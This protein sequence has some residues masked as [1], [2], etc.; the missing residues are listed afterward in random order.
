MA[1]KICGVGVNDAD[2]KV[3]FYKTDG[4]R[5][6]CPFY[7]KWSS[8]INRCYNGS[9]STYDNSEVCEEWK[10]FSNFRKWMI[11]Q[12]WENMELDKDLLDPD[13]N[14]YCPDKCIF[15]PKE[16]NSLFVDS[17]SSRGNC[18][19]GVSFDKHRQ[20]YESYISINNRKRFLGYFDDELSAHNAWQNSKI[21]VLT[22]QLENFDNIYK[23][24]II[25]RISKLQSDIDNGLI[26]TSLHHY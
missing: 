20:K 15:V 3:T 23:N 1:K 13:N 26:T 19:M 4:K 7:R 6:H 2:Y 9:F 12:N 21:Q 24:I 25:S 10:Y 18:P 14:I 11:E 5:G 16:L 8:M 22:N 17:K